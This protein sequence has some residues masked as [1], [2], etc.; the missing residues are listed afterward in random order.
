MV[1]DSGRPRRSMLS[2]MQIRIVQAPGS[3]IRS[4][5][6]TGQQPETAV[7]VAIAATR[8]SPMPAGLTIP[9]TATPLP[10]AVT[11]MSARIPCRRVR[12]PVNEPAGE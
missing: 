11:A 2:A 6:E 5:E 1:A 8:S 4:R 3:Q 10:S 9:P 7:K 12:I